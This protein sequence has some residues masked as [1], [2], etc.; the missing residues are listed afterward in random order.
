MAKVEERRSKRGERP[1]TADEADELVA[2][3]LRRIPA[4]STGMRYHSF[5]IYFDLLKRLGW[6]EET[7]ITEPS[8]VQENYPEA[9]PRR[10]YR[11]TTAGM[12]ATENDLSDP[13]LTLYAYSPEQRSSKKLAES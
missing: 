12:A 11:L 13:V 9:P 2:R 1:L 4:K 3:Y 5:L 10:Y 8:A 6:V 7:E